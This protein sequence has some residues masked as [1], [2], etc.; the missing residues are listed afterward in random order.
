M[1]LENKLIII[2]CITAVQLACAWRVATAVRFNR[3]RSCACFIA[4]SLASALILVAA[5]G[6]RP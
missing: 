5:V 4:V 3:S 1:S 2:A 6:V